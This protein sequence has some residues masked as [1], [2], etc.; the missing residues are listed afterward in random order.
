[1]SSTSRTVE[2]RYELLI[3]RLLRLHWDRLHFG[4]VKQEYRNKYRTEFTK[5]IE[6]AT[7]GDFGDFCVQLCESWALMVA[8]VDEAVLMWAV[9]YEQLRV[10]FGVRNR[11]SGSHKQSASAPM[12]GVATYQSGRYSRIWDI[13][14][15]NWMHYWYWGSLRVKDPAWKWGVEVVSKTPC[16]CCS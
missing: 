14:R 13:L 9:A 10:A 5:D 6:D 2:L 4:A 16:L 3:S 1:M 8:V 12:D 11:T 15:S 7:K